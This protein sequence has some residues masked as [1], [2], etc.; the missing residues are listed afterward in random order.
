MHKPESDLENEMN[1]ILS[2][3]EIQMDY[4]IPARRL[5][6]VLIDKRKDFIN[7]WILPF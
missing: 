1:K 3:F 2:D 6:L 5:D 7:Y 4:P